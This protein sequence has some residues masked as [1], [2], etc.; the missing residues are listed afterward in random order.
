MLRGGRGVI[1]VESSAFN[2]PEAKLE[3]N[4][5]LATAAVHLTLT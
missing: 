4:T 2:R 1:T 5:P 3:T